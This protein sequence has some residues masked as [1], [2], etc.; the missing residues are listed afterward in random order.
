MYF[1]SILRPNHKKIMYQINF[2]A[3]ILLNQIPCDRKK[4]NPLYNERF[5]KFRTSFLFLKRIFLLSIN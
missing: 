5:L 3:L 1:K 4:K 2:G